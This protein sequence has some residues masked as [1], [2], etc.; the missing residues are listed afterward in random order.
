ME[1]GVWYRAGGL[2]ERDSDIFLQ[3]ALESGWGG[4]SSRF[5]PHKMYRGE[6]VRVYEV[7]KKN[8]EMLVVYFRAPS[9][10]KT[11]IYFDFRK[12][13]LRA[14]KEEVDNLIGYV[15]A[16]SE[17]E[18]EAEETRMVSIGMTED[19]VK[20]YAGLPSAQLEP[21]P[22]IKVFVYEHF[23]VIFKDNVVQKI[24]Y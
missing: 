10:L 1:G 2:A 15:F 12:D 9:K 14:S 18:L 3:R 13:A 24:E 11:G 6:K 23:K 8:R 17:E 21:A 22:G 16:F 5:N 4:D 20:K 7:S 19:E